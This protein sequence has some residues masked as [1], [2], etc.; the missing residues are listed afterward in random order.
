MSL[1]AL[2]NRWRD[3]PQMQESITAWRSL[4]ARQ[5]DFDS[6]PAGLPPALQEALL[7]QG[8]SRLYRHQ[9]E[10]WRAA[11]RGENLLLTTGTA[12]GKSLAFHLPALAAAL[13][14]PQARALYLFPT[15][16]LAQDQVSTLSGWLSPALALAPGLY[17]GDTPAA[18]RPVIRKKTRLLFTNPDMLHSGILPHHTLW[19]EFFSGLKFVI[20]DEA[21]VYRGVFGAHVANLLR[22]LKR[23]AAFYGAKPQF[24]LA[25]ATIGN[26]REL[27]EKLIEAPLTLIEADGSGRGERHFLVYNPP[28]ID[29]SLGLRKSLLTES[30]R[31]ARELHQA[32]IQSVIFARS[33]RSV[34]LLLTE[35]EKTLKA[36]KNSL[37][38]Y[39]SGYLPEQRREIERGL[40]EGSVRTVVATTALELG[41]DIGGLGA[42]LL[43]GYPGSAAS[44]TQQA[45]RAGRG[46]APAAAILVASATPLDQFLAHH[47]D[48]LF[49][50]APEQALLDPNHL[51]I[52]L[53]HLRCA[54]FELPFGAGE[55]FGGLPADLLADLLTFLSAEG[56]AHQSGQKTFWMADSYPAAGV[57]L[58][59]ASPQRVS[60]QSAEERPQ[61]IGE[62]EAEAACWMVHPGAVYLHEGQQ[63]FI[64]SLDLE[65]NIAT[66]S[67][68]SLDYYTEPLRQSSVELLAARAEAGA[69]GWGEL[70]VSAQV[71]GFRKIR[72]E[73]RETLG[74]EPL[75]L[76]PQE[77]ETTGF[78]LGIA[79]ETVEA[80]SRAGLWTNAPNEYGPDWP[81][82]RDKIRARDGFRCQNCGAP[83]KN[84]QHDVHHKIPFRTFL[85]GASDVE[86]GR[87]QAN[88][89]ENLV[90]LCPSCH[91]QAEQNVRIRS[92]LA[93]LG[94]LLTQLAPLFLLCDPGDLGVALEPQGSASFPNPAVIFY[95]PV[96]AG[97]GFSERLFALRGELLTRAAQVVA[98]CSCADGCPSCVGPGGENGSG[99][100]IE[101]LALLEKLKEEK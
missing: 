50:R 1:D 35:L 92:G 79:P 3:D 90:T 45:G 13:E 94:Y 2:L 23:V 54:L 11:R 60:I 48:Y 67:A 59:S 28:L 40:R 55:A 63:Y 98:E 7:R 62:V 8:I 31:L 86:S 53:N 32:K 84:R 20:L 10:A 61:S 96:P 12:S 22:R 38:G 95:E 77:L 89:P 39:R 51:L 65:K 66:A 24:L 25:S 57:S 101:V 46:M 15:K 29:E 85:R 44:L 4:P 26:P 88:R 21:H 42:A 30:A 75:N 27:G 78:W 14:N 81:R 43:A 58:R 56:Q 18:Q 52:L 47:P 37:R 41:I 36:E 68:V 17:D 72:W 49:G 99:G 80:L 73:T 64:H 83:E 87:R 5:A 9:S 82:L 100:K 71:A 91:H 69:Q 34:E 76:P 6:L 33:R 97:I 70:R 74:E 19:A 16:A 93:G